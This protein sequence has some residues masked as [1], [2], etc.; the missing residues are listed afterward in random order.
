MCSYVEEIVV[1][2][3]YVVICIYYLVLIW[4]WNKLYNGVFVIG[5]DCFKKVVINNEVIYVFCYRSYIDYLLMFYFLFCNCMVLLYIV[6]GVNL[7]MLVVGFIL[8]WGGVFF[9]CRSFKGNWFYMVVF[10]EYLNMIF[11]CGFFVEYFIEGG[12][13]CIGWLLVLRLGMFFMIVCSFF[14]I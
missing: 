8:C 3:L 14:C 4:L 7:N 1:D 11:D 12:C 10:N 5:I 6:V 13:S 2:Y 9:L